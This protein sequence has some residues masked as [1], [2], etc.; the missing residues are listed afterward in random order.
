MALTRLP[1]F[2]LDSTSSFTFAQA[3]VTGNIFA[4][5][6]NANGTINFVGASNIALGPVANIHITGGTSG[7]V[8]STDGSG[9]LSWV[10]QTGGGGGGTAP[11]RPR[12]A[13]CGQ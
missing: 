4:S 5:N 13:R 6:V 7:Y 2:V 12:T 9:N 10:A 11:R 8:L 3:T 1:G